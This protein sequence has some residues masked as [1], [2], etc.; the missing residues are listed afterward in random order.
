MFFWLECGHRGSKS[1][2]GNQQK[3]GFSFMNNVK[4]A[5]TLILG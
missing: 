4:S 5:L 3:E 1:Y 2:G